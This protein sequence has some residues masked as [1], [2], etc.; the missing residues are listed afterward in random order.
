MV[1]GDKLCTSSLESLL[2]P[3]RFHPRLDSSLYAGRPGERGLASVQKPCDQKPLSPL[4]GVFIA[5]LIHA[6]VAM[7]TP[8]V[9]LF[10]VIVSTAFCNGFLAYRFCNRSARCCC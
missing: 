5:R 6:V 2:L 9:V 3:A 10:P 7:Y 8:C 1:S 4:D